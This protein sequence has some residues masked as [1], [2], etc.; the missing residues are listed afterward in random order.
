MK[1]YFD[2]FV[3]LPIT[4]MAKKISEMTYLYN[5]VEVPDKHY[6]DLLEKTVFELM[7][8]GTMVQSVLLNAI[9]KTLLEL[10]KESPKLFKKALIC[11]DLKIKSDDIDARTYYALD[12]AYDLIE[13]NK[14]MK[15]LNSDIVDTYQHHYE[16]GLPQT[17]EFDDDSNNN[18]GNDF[19]A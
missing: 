9:H 4:K 12:M 3:R 15:L 14:K 19:Q 2:D 17:F 18:N 13:S 8:N 10:E 7:N 5:N 11:M 1:K 16:N 6:K